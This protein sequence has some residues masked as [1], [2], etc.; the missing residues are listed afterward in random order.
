MT[1]LAAEADALR[2]EMAAAAPPLADLK[3]YF[4]RVDAD[5]ALRAA[6]DAEEAARV[7]KEVTLENFRR[8]VAAKKIQRA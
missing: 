1:A 4:A 6:E 2:G 8:R 7:F 5:R 3:Q